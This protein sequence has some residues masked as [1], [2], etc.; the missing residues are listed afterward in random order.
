[1]EIFFQVSISFSDEIELQ[2][3]ILR[4]YHN[5][6]YIMEMDIDTFGRFIN[7]AIEKELEEKRF[8]QWTSI[9]PVMSAFGQYESFEAY[10]DRV[11]GKNI[12]RRSTAEIIAEAVEIEK[13]ANVR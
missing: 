13:K 4:R 8:K 7:K 10:C 11:S 12:D 9:L 6:D 1:M 3:L 2:E 5:I